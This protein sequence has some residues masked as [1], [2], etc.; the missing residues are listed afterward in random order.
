MARRAEPWA[1]KGA[2][3][4]VTRVLALEWGG[5]GVIVTGVAPTFTYPP[6]TA[7]RL[8]HRLSHG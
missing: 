4:Q 8:D 2:L 3:S 7:E 1:S 5:D 6:G